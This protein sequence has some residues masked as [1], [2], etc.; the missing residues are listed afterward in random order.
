MDTVSCEEDL[1]QTIASTAAAYED[2][3]V[4]DEDTTDDVD[5]PWWRVD[6]AVVVLFCLG[7]V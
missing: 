1:C 6:V 2:A 4:T 7:Y 5:G 3:A